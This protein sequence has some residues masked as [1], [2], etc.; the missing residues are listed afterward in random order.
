MSIHHHPSDQT[1]LNYANGS[2]K[3]PLRLV[4]CVHLD[5]CAA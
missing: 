5:A 2:L 1:L 4:A 3:Q